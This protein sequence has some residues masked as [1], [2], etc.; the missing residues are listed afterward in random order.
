MIPANM[1]IKGE[2]KNALSFP[3]L[4]GSNLSGH[5]NFKQRPLVFFERK[6]IYF[7]N[8]FI[9]DISAIMEE[10]RR[11]R[12]AKDIRKAG[13]FRCLNRPVHMA[14]AADQDD[15]SAGIK[16]LQDMRKPDYPRRFN[17]SMVFSF[18]FPMR[19]SSASLFQIKLVLISVPSRMCTK[20]SQCLIKIGTAGKSRIS[21]ALS[22]PVLQ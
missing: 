15:R 14:D 3:N 12:Q 13:A 5:F 1:R 10:G 22:S 11:C 21:E 4:S 6:F 17:C 18:H 8:D 19:F 7:Q 20:F 2:M 16:D 9:H